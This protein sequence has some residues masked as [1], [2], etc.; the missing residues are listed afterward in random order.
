MLLTAQVVAGDAQA[1]PEGDPPPPAP[2]PNPDTPAADADEPGG[3]DERFP[4]DEGT[5]TVSV[6]GEGDPT[7]PGGDVHDGGRGRG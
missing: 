5:P 1:G 6:Y 4:G 2:T 3:G 7:G